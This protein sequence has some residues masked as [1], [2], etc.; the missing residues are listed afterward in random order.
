MIYTPMTKKALKLCFDA[1]K[2]QVDKSGLPYV[3]HPFH[4]AEQMTTEE[5]VVVALLHDLVEDTEYTLE[6]LTAMGFPK[7]ITEAIALMTHA[8]GVD[9]MD[10]VRK[11]K[12]NPIAKAVKLADLKHNSDITRLDVVDEKALLRREKYLQ[13]LAILEA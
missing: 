7:E 13:A 9:Y 10:Y 11:I 2:E 5:T 12:T 1:H 4:L 6:D 8:E 3:F